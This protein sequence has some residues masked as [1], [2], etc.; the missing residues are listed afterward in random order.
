MRLTLDVGLRR[1]PLGV[2]GIEALFEPQVRRD[3]RLDGA[4]ETAFVH[5]LHDVCLQT[6][7]RSAIVTANGPSF[8]RCIL[9]STIGAGFPWQSPK[10]RWPFQVVPVITLAIWDRLPKIWPFQAKPSS[11]IMTR[12]SLPFHSRTS[13]APAFRPTPSRV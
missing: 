13:W 7:R 4:T 8:F 6:M 2:E 11:K 1:P 12:S 10:K 9:S 5:L 3:T